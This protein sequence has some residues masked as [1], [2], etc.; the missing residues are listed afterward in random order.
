MAKWVDQ[1]HIDAFPEATQEE[2]ERAMR[3]TVEQV[4][5]NLDQFRDKFP[6]PNSENNFYTPDINTDW[7]S[8]FWTGE[9]WLAYEQATDPEEKAA[10]REAGEIQVRSFLERIHVKHY[11]D[12]HDMGFLYIPSCVSAYKL[13]GMPEAREAALLAA[14][15]LMTRFQPIGSYIQAWGEMN[16]P[17]NRR[18]IIDCL[19][20]IPLLYW[21]TAETGEP[22][23]REVAE[24]H[25]HTTMRHVVREDRST[26]HT[27]F[28]DAETGNFSHGATCQGYSDGSAW[29]RGQSWGIYGS[30]IAYSYTREE[31]YIEHFR[32]VSS[33]L[34][35]HLPS[36]LCPYWDLSFGDEDEGQEPRDSSTAAITACGFLEMS[37]YLQPEEAAVY[38]SYALKLLKTLLDT[39]QVKDPRISNGQLLHGTYARKTPYNTCRN[40]GVDEC[41]IWGDYFYMEALHRALNPNWVMYW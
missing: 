24:K 12:H 36:D 18:L 27:I 28:F 9:V 17:D 2:L 13:T 26:W 25:I 40:S 33:Y 3:L 7:T 22:R 23:Y 38:R 34:L 30:A 37:K 10:L 5:R 16:A 32:R 29:A 20:N 6:G 35:E 39:Y 14:D 15:Q 1:A 41:V 21:A 8:G 19:L 31:K 4:L 11:V